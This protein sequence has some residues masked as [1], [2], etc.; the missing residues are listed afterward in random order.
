MAALNL[1]LDAALTTPATLPLAF[2]QDDQGDIPPHQRQFFLGS[3]DATGTLFQ[4]AS[5]PGI[6]AIVLS[7]VDAASGSGQ[8]AS[9]IKLATTQSGL[10]SATGGASLTLG[11]DISSGM[12]GAVEIWVQWDDTTG[13]AAT[14]S[15]ISIGL[16]EI[17]VTLP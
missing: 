11:T 2:N 4:A 10:T 9:S 1:Y 13:I 3:T 15:N 8:P 16:N 6:D 7:I 5:D 17:A 12:A 14:D